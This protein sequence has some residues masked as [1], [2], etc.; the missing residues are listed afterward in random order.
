MSF[1]F[2][3]FRKFKL[4]IF[5][6][7][8]IYKSPQTSSQDTK[9]FSPKQLNQRTGT[10]FYTKNFVNPW[11]V[12]EDAVRNNNNCMKALCGLLCVGTFSFWIFTR[13][14]F[15]S[16]D[17]CGQAWMHDF[18][19]LTPFSICTLGARR[20]WRMGE[21]SSWLTDCATVASSL[22]PVPKSCSSHSAAFQAGSH[23]RPAEPQKH[24][25]DSC[26]NF[27]SGKR[28]HLLIFAS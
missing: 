13:I 19:L 15:T 7:I 18:G 2:F 3:S 12:L 8:N 26:H 20:W 23:P 17:E 27:L 22:R 11:F 24:Q 4:Y 6:F 9:T 28:M 1:I 14:I 16:T 10:N 5:I 25:P 21:H